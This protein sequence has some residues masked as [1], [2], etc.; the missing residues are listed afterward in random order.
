MS[1]PI[2]NIKPSKNNKKSD[3]MKVGGGVLIDINYKISAFLFMMGMFIFS[4]IFIDKIMTQ[5]EGAV[6]GECTTTKGTMIQLICLVI[7]YIIIDLV[8]Q[9]EIL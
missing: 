1:E 8:I 3:F 5:F 4:D 9:Y 2:D 6:D 7:G